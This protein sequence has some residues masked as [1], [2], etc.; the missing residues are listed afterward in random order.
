MDEMTATGPPAVGSWEPVGGALSIP[1]RRAIRAA[2]HRRAW[3]AR[4]RTSIAG[5][6]SASAARQ[7]TARRS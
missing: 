2:R 3:V 4:R 6:A 7:G 5:T 1:G